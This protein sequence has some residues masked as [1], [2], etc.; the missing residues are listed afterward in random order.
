MT[1]FVRSTEQNI[2]IPVMA[3][4]IPIS[5]GRRIDLSSDTP[6][7]LFAPRRID[8]DYWEE[9]WGA[10]TIA[11]SR[12]SSMVAGSI[13]NCDSCTDSGM[14]WVQLPDG[15]S[16]LACWAR[17]ADKNRCYSSRPGFRIEAFTSEESIDV[18]RAYAEAFARILRDAGVPC[19][20]ESLLIAPPKQVESGHEDP[21]H[22]S[23]PQLAL[24]PPRITLLRQELDLWFE[25]NELGPDF[26][27]YLPHSE[28][29]DKLNIKWFGDADLVLVFDSIGL[30][31][32]LN[33][34]SPSHL[35]DEFNEIV[36]SHRYYYELGN[37]WN[38]GFY[39]K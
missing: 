16:G 11:A 14:A 20:V 30:Y 18:R 28:D 35:E 9:L 29:F 15:R 6:R 5:E 13:S 32:I 4:I 17:R 1:H 10:A 38:L 12:A 39:K 8:D 36:A 27:W 7:A 33:Y 24:L 26:G 22:C 2:R 34:N 25:K 3:V 19:T 37:A 21:V 23:D 31:E